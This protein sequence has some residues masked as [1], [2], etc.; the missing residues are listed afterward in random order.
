MLSILHLRESRVC[1]QASKEVEGEE[2]TD[3]TTETR[4]HLHVAALHTASDSNDG[5]GMAAAATSAPARPLR[6]VPLTPG[7]LRE[8][9]FLFFEILGENRMCP[10]LE[11]KNFFFFVGIVLEKIVL[12]AHSICSQLRT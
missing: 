11:R 7:T 1:A 3:G 5:N 10:I 12:W 4:V 8:R 6:R 2:D 9:P